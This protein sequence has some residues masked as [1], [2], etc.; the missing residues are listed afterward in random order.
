MDCERA[1]WSP[2]SKRL[3][4]SSKPIPLNAVSKMYQLAVYTVNQS[5]QIRNLDPNA[6]QMK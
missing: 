5:T 6:L 2:S 3:E 4:I 1:L